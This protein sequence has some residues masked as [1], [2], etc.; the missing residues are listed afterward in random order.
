MVVYTLVVKKP[1]HKICHAE[2]RVAR[3]GAEASLGRR[4]DT[5]LRSV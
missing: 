5:S 3:S 1:G 2:A 4:R